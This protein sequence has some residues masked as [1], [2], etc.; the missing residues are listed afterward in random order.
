MRTLTK[1]MAVGFLAT[2]A[3]V[4]A[5]AL[6]TDIPD[7][8]VTVAA[9]YV[10]TVNLASSPATYKATLGNTFEVVGDGGF[11][12]VTGLFGQMNGTLSFTASGIAA[13]LVGVPM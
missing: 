11:A 6:A 1:M 12:D 9:L 7:G 8:T 10:P 3:L 5:P 2:S 13:R 4:S